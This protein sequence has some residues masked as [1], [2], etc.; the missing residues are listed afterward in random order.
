MF[1]ID[2]HSLLLDFLRL[3][4]GAPS[5]MSSPS[6]DSP[7]LS[8]LLVLLHTLISRYWRILALSPNTSSSFLYISFL[9]FSMTLNIQMLTFGPD[10]THEFELTYPPDYMTSLLGCLKG[11]SN[12][13]CPK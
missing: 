7:P 5:S 12:L 9:V 11:M 1:D 8:P 4:F 3:T 6:L 13:I 10:H 2:R